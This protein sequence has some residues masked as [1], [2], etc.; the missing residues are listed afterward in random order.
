MSQAEVMIM[1]TEAKHAI[2]SCD[3]KDIE[4]LIRAAMEATYNHWMCLDEDLQ[5]RAA[6][7]A[8][9]MSDKV[10]EGDKERIQAELATHQALQ[11]LAS[12]VPVDVEAMAKR[13]EETSLIGL[14]NLWEEVKKG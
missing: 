6:I 5:S 11:A 13:A 7:G 14:T 10:S 8:V 12:G 4:D 2:D 1:V 9:L 3:S